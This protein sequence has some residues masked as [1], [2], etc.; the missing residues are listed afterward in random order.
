M[1]LRFKIIL[2][3]C[4][5]I[6]TVWVVYLLALQ[7]YDPFNLSDIKRRRYDSHKEF[8]VANRG[9]IFDSNGAMLAGTI[10]YFQVDIHVE[11][12]RDIANRN[13]KD[14][15]YYF[16]IISDIFSSNTNL[17]K[18]AVSQRLKAAKG[19]SVVISERIDENQL[20]NLRKAFEK[21]RLNVMVS[22]FSSMNRIHTRGSLA[23]RLLG[24]TNGVTDNSTRFSRYTFRLEGLN[25]IEKAFNNDLLGDYGWREAL[26]DGRQNF[27]PKPEFLSKPVTHGSSIYLTIDS[28]IQEILENNLQKGLGLYKAKNAIG[29][30]MNPKNGDILAMAGIN[31]NDKK[32]NDNQ[33]RSLQNMPIQYLFE[34]GSTIKPLVS[35]LAIEKNLFKENDIFDCKPMQL[36][37]NKVR[38]TIKDSHELGK[39]TFRDVI[40]QSSNVGVAKIAEKIGA[41][42]LYKYYLDF[43]FGTTTHVDLNDES[44][45]R[46]SKMSDWTHFTLHSLSFGQ[47][48]SVTALQLANAY[49]ALANGGELLKPNILKYKMDSNGK[50]YDKSSRKVLRKVANK[51]SLELNNSFLLDVVERGTGTNTRFKNIKIAG[52]TGTS[53]K[54]V[55]GKY[56]KY[57]YTSSF[58]GFFPYEDPQFVM[59]IIYDEP[60][61]RF[62]FGSQ[63]A[64]PTFKNIVE[65]LLALP[66]CNIIPD[67]KMHEQEIITMPKLVGLKISEARKILNNAKIDF[68]AYNE[69]KNS[70]VVQQFP[71]PGVQFGSKNKVSI[72]CSE[73]KVVSESNVVI[74]ENI[75]PNLVGMPLRQAI[76]ISKA[77]KINLSIDG[78][79]HIVSQSIKEGE[80]IQFQQKCLVVA[81]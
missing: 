62:R 77:L 5:F 80:K 19:T 47:E 10:K 53:E 78:S 24:L 59:V 11:R 17:N 23:A 64:V 15:N 28:D 32:F 9:C 20:M 40:V 73:D 14:V 12:V 36:Q 74:N 56:S 70:F 66:N 27:V 3:V 79:G 76:S 57:L 16:N 61:Y 63:S 69:S 35:L 25:G 42:S 2:T 58:A 6:S 46:F 72:Y 7:V 44:S 68:H 1:N 31:E 39:I 38:R 22:A 67:I 49:V 33:V 45:G 8:I 65:E 48:M 41:E 29:V 71:Q 50:I 34:P 60:E 75:M 43:G 55:G 54:A 21:E 51:K 37:Y 18:N 13:Q 30:I 81:K 52:K 4:F 26:F